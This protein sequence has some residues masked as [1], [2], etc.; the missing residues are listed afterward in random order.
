MDGA[1]CAIS[2]QDKEMY[3]QSRGHYLTGGAR[4]KHFDLFKAFA[5]KYRNELYNL[6]REK[7]IMY[8]EWLYSKHTIF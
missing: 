2:F 3:L 4:E 1:N 5:A 8:G 7:Y 6:L